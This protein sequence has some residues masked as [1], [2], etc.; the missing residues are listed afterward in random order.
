MAEPELSADEL[1]R[2]LEL[3]S[4]ELAAAHRRIDELLVTARKYKELRE[5]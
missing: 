5:K 3:R 1:A 2:R 4:S